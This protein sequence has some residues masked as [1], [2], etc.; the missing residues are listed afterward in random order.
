MTRVVVL[1]SWQV[2]LARRVA[3]IGKIFIS[4]P[5][6]GIS[7]GSLYRAQKTVDYV[8]PPEQTAAEW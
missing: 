4:H 1:G 5:S 8:H 2:T 7:R 3:I 6:W